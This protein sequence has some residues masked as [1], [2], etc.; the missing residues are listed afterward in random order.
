MSEI[1]ASVPVP[2]VEVF[3]AWQGRLRDFNVTLPEF[4]QAL[5]DGNLIATQYQSGKKIEHP[6]RYWNRARVVLDQSVTISPVAVV[7][8]GDTEVPGRWYIHEPAE[9][10][11][12]LGAVFLHRPAKKWAENLKKFLGG[13]SRTYP[14]AKIKTEIV[15][16]LV[17]RRENGLPA[18]PE[19]RGDL[20]GL[21]REMA[22]WCIDQGIDE[23]P[24]STLRQHIGHVVKGLQKVLK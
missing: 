2:L 24:E 14:W 18:W 1:P 19:K 5:K 21:E 10:M 11:P 16:R 20:A 6:P 12:V 9:A 13:R 4:N 17:N 23:P 22:Q 15:W 7:M 8:E 3:A